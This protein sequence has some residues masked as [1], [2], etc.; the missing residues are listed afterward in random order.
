MAIGG[1]DQRTIGAVDSAARIDQRERPVWQA[2][3]GAGRRPIDQPIERPQTDPPACQ[4]PIKARPDERDPIDFRACQAIAQGDL[5]AID[6]QIGVRRIAHRDCPDHFAPHTDRFD[7]IARG[8]VERGQFAIDQISRDPFAQTPRP[9]QRKRGNPGPDK[10]DPRHSAT[11][12][13]AFV[14]RAIPIIRQI[15]SVRHRPPSCAVGAL[16]QC[17]DR[18][19]R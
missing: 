19:E 15:G 18:D 8:Q 9:A 14:T 16:G 2:Q 7:A 3:G 11:A 6:R 12:R 10:R 13:R 1:K 4:P 5:D 17:K